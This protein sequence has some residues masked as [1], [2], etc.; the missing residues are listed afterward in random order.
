M[1]GKSIFNMAAGM[2]LAISNLDRLNIKSEDKNKL[3]NLTNFVILFK[4]KIND[5]SMKKI[6]V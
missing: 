3:Q 5:S 2:I 6:Y 4:C 1:E